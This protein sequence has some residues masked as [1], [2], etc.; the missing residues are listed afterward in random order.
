M[1]FSNK[2]N[3]DLNNTVNT[4]DGTESYYQQRYWI[5]DLYWDKENGPVFL[6]LCGEGPCSAPDTRKYPFMVGASENA[7]LISIEHRYYGDSQPFTN[8]S[9]ENLK[10]LSSE[11][12]LADLAYFIDEMNAGFQTTIGRKPDW[13]T[14]GGSYA[15][16]LSAWFHS[17][18]PDHA[19]G[20]WSSS[21]VIK[22]IEDFKAYDLQVFTSASRSGE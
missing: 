14:I 21:G 19:I 4:Q 11:Q 20:A 2:I 16:A 10:F 18:Y 12:A 9:T 6:Y 17:Q 7:L 8:W 15:G 22:A 1:W 3:H 13:I 5:N